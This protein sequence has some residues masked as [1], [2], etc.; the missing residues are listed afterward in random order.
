M[1]SCKGRARVALELMSFPKSPWG[2]ARRG[3]VTGRPF[4]FPVPHGAQLLE[5]WQGV[6]EGGEQ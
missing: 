1:T 3:D 2:R 6:L 5:G 4:L